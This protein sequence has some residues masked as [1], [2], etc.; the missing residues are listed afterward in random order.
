MVSTGRRPRKHIVQY[1]DYARIDHISRCKKEIKVCPKCFSDDGVERL[2]HHHEF[3]N[4]RSIN[5]ANDT[6]EII[7]VIV[8]NHFAL[9]KVTKTPAL[10]EARNVRCEIGR[11]KEKL[12][13]YCKKRWT[14]RS[15]QRKPEWLKDELEG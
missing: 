1:Y 15:K 5:E 14:I 6:V 7:D 2:G 13:V 4:P 12:S 9:N 10:D 8:H 3:I 11:R